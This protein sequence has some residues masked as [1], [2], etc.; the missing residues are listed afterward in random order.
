MG[1]SDKDIAALKRKYPKYAELFEDERPQHQVVVSP[2]SLQ[3]TSVTREQYRLYDLQHELVHST[4]STDLFGESD[5]FTKRAPADD[6]PVINVTWYDAW[7]FVRWVGV[8]LPTEAEWEY[9]CRA[10]TQTQ[11]SFGENDKNLGEFAWFSGNSGS[12]THEVRQKKPNAWGLYDMHGNVWE[13]C[14][15]GFDSEYYANS[16]LEDPPGR[17]EAGLRVLR[18]GSWNC[19]ARD[20]RAACRGR[21]EPRI[22][23]DFRAFAWSHFLKP[24]PFQVQGLSPAES[25]AQAEMGSCAAERISRSSREGEKARRRA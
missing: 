10:G 12:T 24:S 15:D 16:P 20:C 4:D 7:V 9:A 23:Y 21:N 8:R 25:G 3:A 6:C 19:N 22:R 11:F 14:Q 17:S 18:G 2:F 1:T 5:V 13:W